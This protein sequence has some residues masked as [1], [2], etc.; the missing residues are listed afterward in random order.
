MIYP[1]FILK[2]YKGR[3]ILKSGNLV[4]IGERREI[5]AKFWELLK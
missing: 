2:P 3:H 1:P 5:L 4:L